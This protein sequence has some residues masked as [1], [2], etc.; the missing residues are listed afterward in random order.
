MRR[1][2]DS[3]DVN[4]AASET[5]HAMKADKGEELHFEARRTRAAET[6]S[7]Q[8]KVVPDRPAALASSYPG[9]QNYPHGFDVV[10]DGEKVAT[11]SLDEYNAD[12]GLDREYLIPEAL[13][14]GKS[15]I[16]VTLQ[17]H[18]KSAAGA[19]MEMRTITR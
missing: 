17:A 6:L 4:D 1:T 16:T 15:S 19:V 2:I 10:V 18:A 12:A 7:H 13:T 11:E 14:R 5:A 3:V 9:K 8:M